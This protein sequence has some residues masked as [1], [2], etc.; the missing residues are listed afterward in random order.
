MGSRLTEWPAGSRMSGSRLR[1]RAILTAFI[2]AGVG[3]LGLIMSPAARADVTITPTTAAQGDGTQVT[4]VVPDDRGT[5]YT[6]KIVVQ[7]P[8]QAPI[9]DV[10][11]MSVS[12]WAPTITYR[13]LATPIAGIMGTSTMTARAVTW[14]RV[15]GAPIGPKVHRLVLAMGPMPQ[16]S[17]LP[18]TVVQ[19]YSDKS[20]SRWDATSGN[21]PVLTLSAAKSSSSGAGNETA[22]SSGMAGMAGMNQ[23]GQ[24]PSTAG[25]QTSAT[26]SGS[27][28]TFSAGLIGGLF[29][30]AMAG[31]W[32]LILRNRRSGTSAAA[33]PAA[34]D[35]VTPESSTT[36][37]STDESSTGESSTGEPVTRQT[38][39]VGVPDSPA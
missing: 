32:V 5:A 23:P 28:G 4:F 7:L 36:E 2:A 9:G 26:T 12:D 39:G 31:T 22:A 6:T 17:K 29:I 1:S 14:S 33:E 37:S 34:N 21:G 25:I 35:A 38:V 27:T 20:V 18:F 15:P 8:E 13:E 19:T 3:A 30:A 11:P 16:V 24:A 10:F